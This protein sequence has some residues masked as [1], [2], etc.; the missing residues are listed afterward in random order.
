MIQRTNDKYIV[1]HA[2]IFDR[3]G[4]KVSEQGS[5]QGGGSQWEESL[6]LLLWNLLSLS[7]SPSGTLPILWLMHWFGML[8][9]NLE[10]YYLV[11]FLR[12]FVSERF[13]HHSKTFGICVG[14]RNIGA[15]IRFLI[16]SLLHFQIVQTIAV[17]NIIASKLIWWR[18]LL[19]LLNMS[20]FGIVYNAV[21]RE[22][23]RLANCFL[24]LLSDIVCAAPLIV[25]SAIRTPQNALDSSETAQQLDVESNNL[26]IG[27]NPRTARLS[28]IKNH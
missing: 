7:L 13:D 18:N 19:L 23:A 25:S 1:L 2:R 12:Y 26:W 3:L 5:D 6:L 28:K 16:L 21:R 24:F 9:Q 27:N 10:I 8:N 22:R 14:R 20:D 11:H 17:S 4:R 15:F